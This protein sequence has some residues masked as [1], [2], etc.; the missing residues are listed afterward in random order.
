MIKLIK[1]LFDKFAAY[2]FMRYAFVSGI[3]FA[4]SL[5]VY[6][7]FSDI[8]GI[9]AVTVSLMWTPIVWLVRYIINKKWVFKQGDKQPNKHSFFRYIFVNIVQLLISLVVYWYFSDTL[10]Y[11]AVLVTLTWVPFA[12]LIRFVIVKRWVFKSEDDK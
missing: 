8:F 2:T 4:I 5:G 11:L 12:W 1:K 6:F 9:L 3:Q 7:L 10:G